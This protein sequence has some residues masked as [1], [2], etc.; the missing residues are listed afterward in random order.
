MPG[1]FYQPVNRRKFLGHSARAL[2]LLAL[3]KR[4]DLLGQ[5]ALDAEKPVRLALE[6]AAHE[7][8]ERRALE[9]ELAPIGMRGDH[10]RA[11]CFRQAGELVHAVHAVDEAFEAERYYVPVLGVDLDARD[12]AE[13]V[14]FREGGGFGW[15]PEEVV[16]GEA[17][18]VEVG[19]FGGIDELVR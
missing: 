8:T 15:V 9:G 11:G 4:T 13:V 6:M 10:H 16:L 12:N 18:G 7:D 19:G 17:D 1:I 3:S 2:A 14:S 5:E